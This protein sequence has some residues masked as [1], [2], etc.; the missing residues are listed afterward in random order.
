[1]RCFIHDTEA[2]AV[3]RKCGKAMCRNCSGFDNHSGFCP[4]CKREVLSARLR[5]ALTVLALSIVA[6]LISISYNFQIVLLISVAVGI[7][8]I[9]IAVLNWKNIIIINKALKEAR[10]RNLL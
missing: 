4:A 9:I 3:C 1:M 6:I 2:V 5:A 8:C 7:V 10:N